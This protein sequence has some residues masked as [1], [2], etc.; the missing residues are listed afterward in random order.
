MTSKNFKF[1]P[2]VRKK[3]NNVF[4]A[5]FKNNKHALWYSHCSKFLNMGG[6]MTYPSTYKQTNKQT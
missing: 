6:V 2:E 5:M 1:S 3:K 4:L